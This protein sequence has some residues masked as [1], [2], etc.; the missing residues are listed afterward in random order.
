MSQPTATFATVSQSVCTAPGLAS[1][2]VEVLATADEQETMVLEGAKAEEVL[3]A[4][5]FYRPINACT[6]IES[7]RRKNHG[8][9]A[10]VAQM[11]EEGS[12]NT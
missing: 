8:N 5:P 10:E 7:N 6:S 2:D 4:S 12:L 11:P 1:T 9:I 3:Q